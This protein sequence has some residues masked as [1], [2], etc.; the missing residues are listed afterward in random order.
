MVEPCPGVELGVDGK[1][2]FL[3]PESTLGCSLQGASFKDLTGFQHSVSLCAINFL[4]PS[5]LEGES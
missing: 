5:I 2:S 4:W 1:D 3:A